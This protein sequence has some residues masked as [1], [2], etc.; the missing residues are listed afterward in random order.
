MV[1]G[2]EKAIK[3]ILLK[4]Y[5]CFGNETRKCMILRILEMEALSGA[6]IRGMEMT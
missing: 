6:A 1:D 5:I 3:K 2:D 4:I